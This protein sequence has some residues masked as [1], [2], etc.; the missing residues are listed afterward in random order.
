M[1]CVSEESTDKTI[2]CRQVLKVFDKKRLVKA[3]FLSPCRYQAERKDDM[4]DDEAEE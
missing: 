1:I 4:T 2:Y 3:V